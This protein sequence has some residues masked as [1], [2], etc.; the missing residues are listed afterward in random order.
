MKAILRGSAIL[1]MAVMSVPG[2]TAERL[3]PYDDF[4]ATH[5]DPDKWVGGGYRPAVPSA[6]TEAIQ[7]I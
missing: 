5:I 4:N 2:D 3:V 6:S 1:V 7:Q